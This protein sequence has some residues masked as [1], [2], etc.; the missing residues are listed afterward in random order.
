MAYKA[1]NI[2][3]AAQK[4]KALRKQQFPRFERKGFTVIEWGGEEVTE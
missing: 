3:E 1:L 2:K 4:K